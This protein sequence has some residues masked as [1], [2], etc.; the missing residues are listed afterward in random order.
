MIE[1]TRRMVVARLQEKIPAT[2][3]DIRPMP[4]RPESFR[5]N[6]PRAALLVQYPGS[7]STQKGRQLERKL[8]IDVYV[9]THQLAGGSGV[10][11]YL[12]LVAAALYGYRA[13]DGFSGLIPVRDRFIDVNDERWQYV[14]TFEC[15]APF[16]GQIISS[17]EEAAP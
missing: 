14:I 7:T 5:L 9:L 3:A 12:D 1:Y 16:Y 2:E 6:H 17:A 13:G 4:D 11:H 10:D 8:M 15:I